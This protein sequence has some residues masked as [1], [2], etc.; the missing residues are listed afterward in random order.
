MRIADEMMTSNLAS[1]LG[2]VSSRLARLQLEVASGIKLQRPSDDPDGALRAA[3]LRT[4]LAQAEQYKKTVNYASSWLKSEDTALDQVQ[5][6]MREV[7]GIALTAVSPRSEQER[8]TYAQQVDQVID[9]LKQVANS[10]DGMHYLFAGHQTLSVPFDGTPGAITYAGDAG[11]RQLE[12]GEGLT[13]SLNHTGGQVFNMGGTADAGLPDLFT[14]LAAIST[15]ARAG[16][17]T[18]LTQ[19]IAQLDVHATRVTAIRAQTGTRLQ[20]LEMATS[21]LTDTT[22][23]LNDLLGEVESVDI[24]EALVHLKEQENVYQAASYVASSLASGGL[25]SWLR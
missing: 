25:L 24:T 5:Q 9:A 16:D 15:Q 2:R 4:G 17:S 3:T 6:L 10:T 22:L 18:G 19:S 13:M 1:H 8:E 7:R 20:Q 21:R 12:I 14:T 11:N 23:V